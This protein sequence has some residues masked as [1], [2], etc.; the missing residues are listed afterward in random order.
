[1]AAVAG[2]DDASTYV[3][4]GNY[5]HF[6]TEAGYVLRG[7]MKDSAGD[8][9]YADNDGR[10]WESGWVIT[11]DVTGDLERY[12]MHEYKAVRGSLVSTD[13]GYSYA[14]SDGRIVRGHLKVDNLV[15]LSDNDG[16][17]QAGSDD[18]GGWVV[19][20][21]YGQG[22]QRYWI[23]PEAHACIV[24]YDDGVSYNELGN[25]AHCTT[26]EGYVAR[27]AA[28]VGNRVY[29]GDNDGKLLARGDGDDGSGWLVS[30]AYGQ[31][32]QRY[33][34]EVGGWA[35]IGYS[36]SGWGHYTTSAGYVA[37]D[38]HLGEDGYV[39]LANNDGLLETGDK[40]GW[41]VTAAYDGSLQR[42]RIDCEAHACVPGGF[43]IGDYDFYTLP[44]V[45]WVLRGTAT[46][47]DR[48]WYAD[49][50]GR[51]INAVLA[52]AAVKKSGDATNIESTYVGD[53]M[54][55]FLPSYASLSKVP[56]ALLRWSGA[57]DIYL[58]GSDNGAYKLYETFTDVD[59]ESLSEN[60]LGNGARLLYYK[61][62]SG[63][64]T[65]KLAV[66]LSSDV[67]SV[68]VLSVDRDNEGRNF[69]E[70]SYDHTAK[71]SVAVVVVASDGTVLYNKDDVTSGS[72]STI[73]GRGNTTWHSGSK[74]P[75]QISLNKKADLL[76]TG[77][78]DNAKKKWVLLAN[79]SDVTLLR[80]TIA[81][82][83]A[84]EFGVGAMESAPAD[85]W[86]DGEYRGSYLLCE[87][88]EVNGGRVDIYD[89]ESDIEDAN[90][91]VDLDRL[92]IKKSTNKY[93]NEFQYVVGVK[94]PVD[95]SGGYLLETD[96]AYY[97]NEACYFKSS[98]GY[99]VVKSPE[100]CSEN[101]MR[102]ISEAFQAALNQLE[103]GGAGD[104]TFDVASLSKVY[105]I[106]EYLK[107]CDFGF[108]STYY[109]I[110]RDGRS[111]V[112]SPVWD[113]DSSMGNRNGTD[114]FFSY[115]SYINN[116]AIWM[117]N[118]NKVQTAVKSAYKDFSSLIH[119]VL[120]GDTGA[121]GANGI[122]HSL[123]YYRRTIDNSEKM[124]EVIWGLSAFGNDHQPYSTYDR[125]YEYLAEWLENRINWLDKAMPSLNGAVNTWEP[126]YNGVNYLLVFD[127]QYY[128]EMN[129]DV[130]SALGDSDEAA[131]N[132]FV[133]YGMS[134][135]RVSSRNF[136]VRKYADL[137]SDLRSAFGSNWAAYYTHYLTYGFYEGRYAK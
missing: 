57:T 109:Y 79:A 54:Y 40:D 106:N 12:W 97:A 56:I 9:Y 86:Y 69:V 34:V 116:D 36:S 8:V 49:N 73:K 65:H 44:T 78:S 47:G 96:S 131:F 127:A 25:Y 75:Y 83:L 118:N 20:S 14:A 133:T 4:L 74:K 72:T 53:T 46:V 26:E 43:S 134:E 37:R 70:A 93:G 103:N 80:N 10:L 92:P 98:R 129:P 125:N 19:S 62:S 126:I 55:L 122:L 85:L 113:F 114:R 33:W 1:H 81:Y 91:G 29:L 135:G 16:R 3:D 59:I 112:A 90:D 68:F 115:S 76:G 32:L 18:K 51:I 22:L 94:D 124:D 5:A 100:F 11:A 6:T 28:R 123:D 2:Y 39:Y 15:Y 50:D 82:N 42:Y 30:S 58:S 31:G 23:D 88:V 45:G 27:A 63:S 7:G 60:K 77:N 38:K 105:L 110:D 48:T 52:S 71:A 41:L 21:A 17:L 89:L 120:L 87:K 137:N 102:Y 104:F 64:I 67:T 107:N 13:N 108:S 95:Y 128:K 119:D 130:V 101:A 61:T 35:Q 99:V 117:L 84:L 121:V 136:N 111:F 66:M 132:H 24:G